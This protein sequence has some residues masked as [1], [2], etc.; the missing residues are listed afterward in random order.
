MKGISIVGLAMLFGGIGLDAQT[1]ALVTT[2]LPA[3]GA[4]LSAARDLVIDVDTP[5]LEATLPGAI[6]GNHPNPG[7]RATLSA[8]GRFFVGPYMRLPI[9]VPPVYPLA[10]RDLVTGAT[11]SIRTDIWW[12]ASNP[13]RPQVL[14]ALT[15]GDVGVIDTG[16]ID[17]VTLTL[18][19]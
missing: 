10:I 3:P 8:D 11:T 7:H 4:P 14:M 9:T 5:A 19:Y 17:A 13:R 18:V 15:G 16:T 1:R 12:T 6:D 2:V